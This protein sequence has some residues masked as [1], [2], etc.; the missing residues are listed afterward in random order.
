MSEKSRIR[1]S[2]L[3]RYSIALAVLVIYY[4]LR[5]VEL[6]SVPCPFHYVTGLKCPGCGMTRSLH[7]L[8]HGRV[9]DSLILNPAVITALASYLFFMVNTTLCRF[10]KKLGFPKFP[11]TAVIFA[12]LIFMVLQCI[13]RNIIHFI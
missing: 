13:V 11:V 3:K 5:S 6:L 9:W 1:R 4:I 12:N 10:T 8:L 2:L 7:Q